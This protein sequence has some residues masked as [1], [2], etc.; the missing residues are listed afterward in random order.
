MKRKN[1]LTTLMT[2]II[3]ALVTFT[4]TALWQYGKIEN[5]E[6]SGEEVIGKAL[7][8]D[9]LT[10]K[11]K[12]IRQKIDNSFVGEV[13]D[14]TLKEYAVKGFVA[15]LDDDYSQYFTKE[16]MKKYTE[17]TLG[18]YVGIG[19]YMSKDK[20]KNTIKVHRVIED[21][22]AQKS[23]VKDN[24]VIKKVEDKEI[25]ADDFDN[26]ANMIE[27]KAGTKV[28]IVFDRD[29]EEITKDITREK[30]VIKS[31]QSKMIDNNIGYIYI[32]TFDGDVSKEFKE[33]YDKLLNEG[34]KSLVIDMRNN[35]G[36]VAKEAVEIGD[37]FSEKGK[38]LLIE[39]DKNKKEEITKA[40]RDKEITMKTA[41]LV[42]ENSASASEILAAIL[43]ENADNATVVGKKTFGKGVIQTLYRLSDGSGLKITTNKYYTPNHNN[44]DKEGVIPDIETEKYDF[45]GELKKDEDIQLN[46]AIDTLNN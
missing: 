32:S 22:P 36:G 9:A 34:M 2:I 37:Y 30:I 3:T 40:D 18:S 16:E 27:G 11:L 42:N 25:T 43:K 41:V 35:G 15:G 19:I 26:I 1:I 10:S 45:N 7:S 21:S 31:V 24:D 39:E 20:E 46:K 17:D 4:V 5:K 23:G 44:I 12:Q 13:N 14:D 29:G 38:N 8:E 28:K 6:A 33:S